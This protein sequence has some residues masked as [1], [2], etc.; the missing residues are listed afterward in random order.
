MYINPTLAEF[1]DALERH[2]WWY[3]MSDDHSV[4]NRGA[5][6]EGKLKVIAKKS[7]EHQTLF[8]DMQAFH[9]GKTK[10]KPEIPK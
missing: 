9:T 2:D 4:Y 1:Y 5:V 7:P 3:C 10:V 6:A 8:D